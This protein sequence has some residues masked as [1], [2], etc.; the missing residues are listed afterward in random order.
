VEKWEG[1]DGADE[2]NTAANTSVD[3]GMDIG[4]TSAGSGMDVDEDPPQPD[5]SEDSDD[6][7]E[8]PSDVASALIFVCGEGLLHPRRQNY[9]TKK[10]CCGWSLRN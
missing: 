2:E 7:V 9:F 3:S 8:D 5:E 4:N 1:E 6:D 10:M